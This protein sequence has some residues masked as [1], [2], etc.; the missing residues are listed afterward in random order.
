MQADTELLAQRALWLAR[1]ALALFGLALTLLLLLACAGW[2]ALRRDSL[3]GSPLWPTRPRR[4][5]LGAM[6]VVLGAAVFTGLASQIGPGSALGQADVV[7]GEA[8]SV[9]FAITAGIP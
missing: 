2:W 3:A 6:V 8:L 4:L 9:S 5:A 7:L 1:H